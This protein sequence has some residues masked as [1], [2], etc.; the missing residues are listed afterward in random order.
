MY[1]AALAVGFGSFTQEVLWWFSLKRK[2]HNEE[3]KSLITSKAYYFVSCLFILV[4]FGVGWIWFSDR[5]EVVLRDAFVLGVG[6][7]YLLKS[8]GANWSS[9]KEKGEFVLGSSVFQN[10]LKG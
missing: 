9:A 7:P 2:L 6:M 4:S 3:F 5:S 1:E 10:Y 8:I